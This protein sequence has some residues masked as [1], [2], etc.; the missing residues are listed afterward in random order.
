MAESTIIVP[1]TNGKQTPGRF[2]DLAAYHNEITTSVNNEIEEGERARAGN[3]MA[4]PPASKTSSGK[5]SLTG[6]QTHTARKQL[7]NL[8]KTIAR[9][10]GQKK[11]LNK[12][13]LNTSDA[14]RALLL[15]YMDD[16]PGREMA[17]ITGLSEG[18][19]RV[20]VHR[21][22]QRLGQWSVSDV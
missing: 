6:K 3:K 9:L 18:A 20:R 5:S 19:I 15:L 11:E 10:D 13:M 14:D 8:E 16:V 21:I 17:E 4:A 22:K 7:R 2:S 1:T 12:E